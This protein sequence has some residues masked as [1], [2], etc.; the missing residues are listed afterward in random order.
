MI[1]S[2]GV[3]LPGTYHV[4]NNIVCQ[5]AHRIVK[6]GDDFGIAVVAD[7]LGSETYSDVASR[8]AAD[9]STEYC[10]QNITQENSADEILDVISMSFASAQRAIEEEAE[11]N[12]HDINQYDTTLT[13]AVLIND[14]LYYGHS[15]DS[16]IVVLTTEGRYES[17]TE[18]QRDE[19]GYVYPLFF[20]DMWVF[21]QFDKKVTSVFLATDG[22]YETLFPYLIRNEPV[23]IHV[24]LAQ[25]FMD[26]RDLKIDE[27]GETAVQSRIGD[28]I[29]SIPDEQVNDDKTVVVLVNTSV[30]FTPQ[31]DEYY[32][33]PDWAEL[34]RKHYDE[35]KRQAYPHL[36]KESNPEES[37]DDAVDNQIED[38]NEV[39]ES[40]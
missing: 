12:G 37:L 13:L 17:V 34:K 10:R 31:P 16:G 8:I 28:F 26:N 14:T 39:V 38:E 35:W 1:Y 2:Y 3:T 4:K 25:F 7:G 24:N 18:Q 29:N 23:S 36:F 15:G 30:E 40:K 5:D 9:L 19:E 11:S 33:E 27:V 6:C 32:K 22:M 21:G 20:E